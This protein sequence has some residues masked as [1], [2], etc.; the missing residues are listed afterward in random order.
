MNWA[1]NAKRNAEHTIKMFAG[2]HNVEL[3]YNEKSIEVLD[4]FINQSGQKFNDKQREQLI[5]FLGSFLGEVIRVNY[6]GKWEV[7]NGDVGIRFDET[8][9]VFPFN[10][11]RKQF[12]NGQ[13]DSISSFYQMIPFIFK[14]SK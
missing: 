8:N 6:G 14:T 10:K 5:D 12:V 11:I 13:E 4:D 9:A 3:D 7:I 2:S 1:E